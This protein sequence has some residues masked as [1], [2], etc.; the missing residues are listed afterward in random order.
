MDALL[1]LLRDPNGSGKAVDVS[2]RIANYPYT[3]P[4]LEAVVRA[5]LHPV[6]AWALR[7]QPPRA[8]LLADPLVRVVLAAD[9]KCGDCLVAR[10][11]SDMLAPCGHTRKSWLA[12]EEAWRA[13]T[14]RIHF[15]DAVF[16]LVLAFLSR[17]GCTLSPAMFAALYWA[18]PPARQEALLALL[19]ARFPHGVSQVVHTVLFGVAAFPPPLTDIAA[20]VWCARVR[21]PKTRCTVL[22]AYIGSTLLSMEGWPAIPRAYI[23]PTRETF[24]VI[25]P[26]WY[27]LTDWLARNPG[28]AL[29][30]GTFKRFTR[31]MAVQG[32]PDM[33][34]VLLDAVWCALPDRDAAPEQDNDG[35]GTDSGGVCAGS[36]GG[37]RV[38]NGRACMV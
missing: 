13:C 27:D 38:D 22:E 1:K 9:H 24:A 4:E 12:S 31:V 21:L 23:H 2:A 15:H 19:P 17:D 37:A 10:V 32:V 7:H 26:F 36:G 18:V 29:S 34:F 16:Q 20:P 33:L 25:E 11:L 14:R 5:S 3:L 30:Q 28:A 6:V 35:A 8:V